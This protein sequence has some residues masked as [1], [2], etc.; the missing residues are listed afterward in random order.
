MSTQTP[1]S[2]ERVDFVREIVTADGVTRIAN[3]CREPELF[4]AQSPS[5]SQ[6]R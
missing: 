3:A 5:V 1:T 4:W 2:P 6:C